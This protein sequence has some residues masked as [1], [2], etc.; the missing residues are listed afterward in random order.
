[1]LDPDRRI[2]YTD[3]LT[4]P[5]GYAFDAAVATTY[6]LDLTTV[7]SLPLHLVMAA[8]DEAE[9]LLRDPVALHEALQRVTERLT[10]FCH[11][12]AIHAPSG[13]HPLFTL[14]EPLLVEALPPG[15]G[16]FHPKVWLIRFLDT[17]DDRPPLYRLMVGSRNI[18]AD[19]SWDVAFMTEGA[20][21]GRQLRDNRALHDFLLGTADLAAKRLDGPRRELIEDLVTGA[22]RVAWDPPD[23]FDQIAFHALGFDRPWRLPKCDD[24]VVISPFVSDAA[25]RALADRSGQ[26]PALVSRSDWVDTLDDAT[27]D[28]FDQVFILHE[29]AETEDG[30]D[31]VPTRGLD[32]AACGGVELGLHA[33]AYLFEVERRLHVALGSANATDA[34]LLHGNNVEFMVELSGPVKPL[35]SPRQL[36]QGETE[37]TLGA[38]LTP[39]RRPGS[40]I[41]DTGTRTLERRLDE[42]RRAIV[43]TELRVACE[44]AGDTWRLK[45]VPG[46]TVALGP[47]DRLRCWPVTT[48]IDGAVDAMPLGT[49]QT[50]EMTVQSLVSVTGLIA[51]ELAIEGTSA[52]F[53]L[54]LPVDGLPE[55]RSAAIL[56]SVVSNRA[57]F[58]RY[59]LLLLAGAGELDMPGIAQALIRE[60]RA[61]DGRRGS[62]DAIPLLEELVRTYA[63][64]PARL[65]RVARLVN[66]LGARGDADGVLPE[67]FLALWSVFEEALMEDA[68]A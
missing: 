8:A 58:L 66:D 7:L 65:R 36:L 2:L 49:G 44:A 18:T 10:L 6:S 51:F 57:A 9:T 48:R 12:G 5:A 53:V 1:M 30:E 3:A 59:L 13:D 43:K 14:L 29:A 38:L 42:V 4:P 61:G 26:P 35:G 62:N 20:P 19:R 64:E 60:A 50:I 34:A 54:N 22:L 37:G 55:E 23:G 56:R 68:G 52:T 41:P 28:R 67:G 46:G 45:L 33:K 25:L 21:S 16:A 39:Y 47:V 17:L 32:E 63:R 24:L 11:R 15:G 27:L 31:V 40:P